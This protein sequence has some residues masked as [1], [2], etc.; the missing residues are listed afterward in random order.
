[1]NL[2]GTFLGLNP[3]TFYPIIALLSVLA[4][5]ITAAYVLRATNTVFFGDYDASKWHDMKPLLAIDKF[6]LL[7]SVPFWS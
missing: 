4:I 2:Q 1:M 3:A 7:F 6:T 5:I